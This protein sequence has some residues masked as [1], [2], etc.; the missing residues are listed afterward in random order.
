MTTLIAGLILFFGIHLLP[1]LAE[2]R[3]RLISRVGEGPYKVIF[4]FISIGG[5]VLI[6]TGMANRDYISVWQP[7]IW[8]SHLTLVVML[9]VFILLAAAYLPGNI[10]RFTRHPM[11]WGVT[12]WAVAHL[13]ANGDL[14]AILLFGSFLAYSLF[15][16]WSANSRGAEKS[17][18]KR[19]LIYDA[20][21]VFLGLGLY[22][23]FFYIHPYIA[24]VPVI[25]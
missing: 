1:A 15:D 11:L 7:P 21:L 19:P 12:F 22:L 14:G 13:L 10:K 23:L 2:K 17:S 4:A 20:G 8:T 25:G 18:T 3:S 9:P 24:G 5:F 6:V 16:M